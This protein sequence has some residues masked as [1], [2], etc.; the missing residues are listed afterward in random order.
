[1]N[2][3]DESSPILVQ[4]S[5]YTFIMAPFGLSIISIYLLREQLISRKRYNQ[6]LQSVR[7][8]M[9]D[10]RKTEVEAIGRNLHDNVGNILATAIGY[11]RLHKPNLDITED[12]LKESIKEIRFLSHNLVKDDHAPLHDKIAS[13]VSRFNDFSNVVFI[14][15]DYSNG[16]LNVLDKIAQQNIYMIV[17]E[18]FTNI[19]KHANAT[20]ASIQIFE[21]DSHAL[22]LT[23]EDDGIGISNFGQST[24]IGLKNIQKRADI[25][26]L[27]L[28]IDSTPA[29]TNFIIET[30]PV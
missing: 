28:T 21:T 18:I 15:E 27:K 8:S 20:E 9:E 16:K 30:L 6:N 17:Q 19:L 23:I 5:T 29:G 10:I 3:L 7:Q 1:M 26:N 11:L 25:S 22:Q 12:L 13:L 14:F 4:V 24:G 2:I